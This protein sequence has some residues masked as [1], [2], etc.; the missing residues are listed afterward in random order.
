MLCVCRH[1]I[2]K[3]PTGADD[4]E[5]RAIQSHLKADPKAAEAGANSLIA[6]LNSLAVSSKAPKQQVAAGSAS[7]SS[8]SSASASASAAAGSTPSAAAPAPA[9]SAAA[10]SN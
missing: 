9:A 1:G 6:S 8:D 2:L 3:V 10:A 5:V 7:A 4:P